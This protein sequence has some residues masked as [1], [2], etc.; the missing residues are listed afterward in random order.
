LKS[1]SLAGKNEAI[2]RQNWLLMEKAYLK[3]GDKEKAIWARQK[4]SEK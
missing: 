1:N 4:A 2:I 3:T